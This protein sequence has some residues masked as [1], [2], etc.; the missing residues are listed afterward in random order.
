MRTMRQ[1]VFKSEGTLPNLWNAE[2]E[3][4][5]RLKRCASKRS[6]AGICRDESLGTKTLHRSVDRAQQPWIRKEHCDSDAHSVESKSS[7]LA[8]SIAANVRRPASS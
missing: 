5:V 2:A 4:S 6:S 7:S 3:V 8:F 1:Q